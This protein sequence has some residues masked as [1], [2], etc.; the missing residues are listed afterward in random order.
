MFIDDRRGRSGGSVRRWV[1]RVL[2]VGLLV[3][4]VLAAVTWWYTGSRLTPIDVEA[5]AA[6]P[7][8]G[9]GGDDGGA[10]DAGSARGLTNTL[11]VITAGEGDETSLDSVIL[12]QTGRT[13]APPVAV[14]FP[15]ELLVTSPGEGSVRLSEVHRSGGA[16]GMV[17]T[18]QDFTGVDLDHYV[19][20][21]LAGARALTGALGGVEVCTA[22]AAEEGAQGCDVVDAAGAAQ[23]AAAEGT[24][25]AFARLDQR[26]RLLRALAG[27]AQQVGTMA[28]PL[29]MKRLVDGLADHVETDR[30]LGLLELRSLA[31]A[32]AGS[33]PADVRTVPAT[34][35]TIDGQT[36]VVAAPE[37][38]TAL[39]DALATGST[40][41]AELGTAEAEALAPDGVDVLVINGVGISGLAGNVRD[42]LE[43][44]SFR[45]LD[46]V[47]PSDLDPDA[48]FDTTLRRMTIRHT[49]ATRP[50]AEV[51]RDHLGDVP[52]DLEVMEELP[53]KA[54]VV[55][56]VGG[57]WNA[58]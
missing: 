8:A 53:K 22:T 27:E 9:D 47:N 21:D 11:V 48:E 34:L 14:L 35:Q 50:H 49:E 44:R 46:A 10:G 41:D 31:A 52:V 20:S 5:L 19:Q 51:L 42:Y 1:L 26:A 12:V 13:G 17:R 40:L 36:Q 30:D 58:G 2:L 37:Q 16:D 56:V 4:G 38:A 45:V 18:V 29:E 57:A 15:P 7:D 33:E 24:D 23:L 32:L 55:L 28:N 54:H 25:D 6:E 39:F 3:V 43:A